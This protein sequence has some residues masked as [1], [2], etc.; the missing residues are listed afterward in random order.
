MTPLSSSWAVS[1]LLFYPRGKTSLLKGIKSGD[2]SGLRGW[3]VLLGD[4]VVLWIGSVYGVMGSLLVLVGNR[5][6]GA[7]LVCICIHL[8]GQ[9]G[10]F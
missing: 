2:V 5:K 1:H 7:G 4:R 6:M 3:R 9:D 8:D 10:E